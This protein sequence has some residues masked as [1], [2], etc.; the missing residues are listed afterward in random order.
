MKEALLIWI[1]TSFVEVV[2]IELSHEWWEIIVFE[3][4]REYPLSEIIRLLNDKG[5][6][7]L[8]PADYIV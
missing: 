8:I 3:V 1:I 7:G 6:P 5:L 2:H 4:P